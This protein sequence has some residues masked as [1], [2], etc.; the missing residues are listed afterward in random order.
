MASAGTSNTK[1]RRRRGAP[2]DLVFRVASQLQGQIL[3]GRYRSYDR[4]PSEGEM[5]NQF[6]V[7]RTVMREAMRTLRARGLV[8]YS[9]GRRPHVASIDPYVAVESLYTF[10]ERSDSSLGDLFE[11]RRVIECQIAALAAARSTPQLVEQL[12]ESHRRVM[13]SR[14]AQQRFEHDQEFHLILARATG[15]RVLELFM[16]IFT[17]A[18]LRLRHRVRRL[19]GPG[20][21]AELH[22]MIIDAVR[23][24]DPEAARAAML[25]HLKCFEDRFH[26]VKDRH[27][28]DLS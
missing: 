24:K 20:H 2:N 13:E 16:E 8:E 11:A 12:S 4:L 9:Q 28:G 23:R 7:S 3:K 5:A 1:T 10:I 25:Q 21:A 15:N 27:P 19:A 14:T 18:M 22:E 6:N 17:Q 26:S